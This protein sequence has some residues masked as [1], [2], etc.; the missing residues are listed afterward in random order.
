MIPTGGTSRYE[1]SLRNSN[2]EQGVAS[3]M[4]WSAMAFE[5][6]SLQSRMYV[7]YTEKMYCAEKADESVTIS[8]KNWDKRKDAALKK[9][10]MKLHEKEYLKD[11]VREVN[12]SEGEGV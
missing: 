5:G 6:Y 9:V 4:L 12:S 7:E 2:V 10:N 8:D 3:G 1:I 11:F